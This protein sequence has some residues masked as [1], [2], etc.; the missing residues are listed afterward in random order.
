MESWTEFQPIP[1]RFSSAQTNQKL[2][3][4]NK[5]RVRLLEAGAGTYDYQRIRYFAKI[6][7]AG[8]LGQNSTFLQRQVVVPHSAEG[9][10]P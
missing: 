4:T 6:L 8:R 3:M 5:P 1:C 9:K 7:A 2:D 10:S